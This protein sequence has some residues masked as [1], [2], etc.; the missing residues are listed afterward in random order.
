MAAKDDILVS[1]ITLFRDNDGKLEEIDDLDLSFL[2]E[3]T[4]IEV[5]DISG[6]RLILT[7]ED[8]AKYITDDLEAKPRDVLKVKFS[9][10]WHEGN[11]SEIDLVMKF[12]IITMPQSGGKVEFNCIEYEVELIKQP[13][14]KTM[15]FAE[16]PVTAIIA[17][18]LPG[19]KT[20]VGKFPTIMDYH[21]LPGM[22]PAK[23]LRQM[24]HELK[25]ACFNRRGT[26]VFES[27]E[28]LTSQKPDFTYHH[29]PPPQDQSYDEILSYEL[30]STQAVVKDRVERNYMSFNLI[31]GIVST[32]KALKMATQ[33]VAPASAGVLDNLLTVPLPTIDLIASGKGTLVPGKVMKIFWHTSNQEKPIDESRPAKILISTVAHYYSS[34]SYMCRVKG[35]RIDPPTAKAGEAPAAAAAVTKATDSAKATAAAETGKATEAATAA[36]NASSAAK[37]SELSAFA[38]AKAAAEAAQASVLS[39]IAAAKAAVNAQLATSL[40]EVNAALAIANAAMADI[41]KAKATAQS[42]AATAQNGVASVKSS[43]KN[44]QNAANLAKQSAKNIVLAPAKIVSKNPFSAIKSANSA[45]AVLALPSKI[46]GDASS[47][48]N[49]AF[50]AASSSLSSTIGSANASVNSVTSIDSSYNASKKSVADIEKLASKFTG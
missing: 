13:A 20:A 11:K 34:N 41:E 26:V 5:I 16:K 49:G 48:A 38:A 36:A 7:I 28:K 37:S 22:R 9:S 35:V 18:L 4:F 24:C 8:P 50:N 31:D 14:K 1:Q 46:A 21:I 3:F 43:V 44:A 47:Q 25:A 39:K 30:I 29:A 17:K 19:L 33:W 45:K 12:R 2:V 32:S 15:L 23:V 10:H 6:P 40:A 27:W 42:A